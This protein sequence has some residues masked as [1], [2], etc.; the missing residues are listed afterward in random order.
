MPRIKLQ[1][2]SINSGSVHQHSVPRQYCLSPGSPGTSGH[3]KVSRPI[4]L[5]DLRIY[6]LKQALGSIH[7][8][9]RISLALL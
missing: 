7:H 8:R 2:I 5:T 1:P 4:P 3:F 6:S 9:G